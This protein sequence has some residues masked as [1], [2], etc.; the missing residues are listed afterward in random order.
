VAGA[1]RRLTDAG[2]LVPFDP[3]AAAAAGAE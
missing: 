2:L 1:A 3:N